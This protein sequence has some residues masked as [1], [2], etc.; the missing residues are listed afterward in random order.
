MEDAW[1]DPLPPVLQLVIVS[2]CAPLECLLDG[3]DGESACQLVVMV[4]HCCR[5]HCPIPAMLATAGHLAALRRLR[6]T[7]ESCVLADV[8]G[9]LM[10]ACAAGRVNVC[11]WLR[12]TYSPVLNKE[13]ALA[14]GDNIAVHEWLL[15][16]W[17]DARKLYTSG[18]LYFDLVATGRG[19]FIVWWL[20][21]FYSNSPARKVTV[22]CELPPP[23]RDFVVRELKI[24]AKMM[25]THGG[26]THFYNAI[27]FGDA[28]RVGWFIS[29]FKLTAGDVDPPSVLWALAAHG[30]MDK[31]RT[32]RSIAAVRAM[33]E[34]DLARWRPHWRAGIPAGSDAETIIWLAEL[35]GVTKENSYAE[36][37]ELQ[38][39]MRNAWFMRLSADAIEK[40][41]GL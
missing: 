34:S 23:K 26:L 41:F 33:I 25:A 27:Q 9:T 18:N 7:S 14:A 12:C 29:E 4:G 31:T 17:P 28:E 2:F 30:D 16:A 39:T 6:Q 24:D 36:I 37:Y 32:G 11:E 8:D 19:R 13:F 35:L 20:E 22:V 3:V 10:R 38:S 21:R 5:P 15:A 1:P 40:H